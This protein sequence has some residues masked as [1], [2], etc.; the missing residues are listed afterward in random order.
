M[1]IIS[2]DANPLNP[3]SYASGGTLIF[4]F[5]ELINTV[6]I[7]LLN[8]DAPGWSIDLYDINNVLIASVI[9]PNLGTNSFQTIALPYTQVNRMEVIMPGIGAV[10]AITYQRSN[11][12][13]AQYGYIQLIDNG[14]LSAAL[15][16]KLIGAY[17]I[18]VESIISGGA[19]ATFNAAKASQTYGGNLVRTTSSTSLLGEQLNILWSAAQPINLIH[20]I[21]RTISTGALIT[22]KY[23][24]SY[25]I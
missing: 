3:K 9:P 24:I 23:Y 15:P 2:D 22:Y 20:S 6:S 10:G 14:T 17:Q 25:I 13:G 4:N 19:T 11:S 16:T 5:T 18:F 8:V 21:P 12:S 7:D 1:W